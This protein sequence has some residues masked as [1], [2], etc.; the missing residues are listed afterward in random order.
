M[1]SR[2]ILALPGRHVL[3]QLLEASIARLV[4]RGT[5]VQW[6]WNEQAPS[7]E[8]AST[9]RHVNRKSLTLPVAHVACAYPTHLTF[10]A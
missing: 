6:Q 3:M 4:D 9:F 10:S 7:F 5:W 1:L 8:T 2:V